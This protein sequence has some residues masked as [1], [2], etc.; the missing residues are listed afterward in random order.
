MTNSSF[1]YHLNN[2]NHCVFV[3]VRVNIITEK[4][5][6]FF[7]LIEW[8]NLNDGLGLILKLQSFGTFSNEVKCVRGHN[9]QLLKDVS[10]KDNYKWICREKIGNKKTKKNCN[11]R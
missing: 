3:I 7:T 4:Y 1:Q 10:K 5:I 11:Y 2:I 6:D 9:M 8:S